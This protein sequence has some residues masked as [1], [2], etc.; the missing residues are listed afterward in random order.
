MMN[1]SRRLFSGERLPVLAHTMGR[2]L[3]RGVQRD[4]QAQLSGGQ[5]TSQA[6]RG[7]TSAVLFHRAAARQQER[8]GSRAVS[9]NHI[10]TNM[11]N[12]H[13]SKRGR[14]CTERARA[15]NVR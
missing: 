14:A 8:S 12:G 15:R 5:G 10:V 9:V 6:A 11:I 7:L 4:V 13:V 2:G 1:V 3:R